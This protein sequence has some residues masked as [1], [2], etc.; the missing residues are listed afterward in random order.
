MGPCR[1]RVSALGRGGGRLLVRGD[2]GGDLEVLVLVAGT[3]GGRTVCV[4]SG[5]ANVGLELKVY[6]SLVG[7]WVFPVCGNAALGGNLVGEG[8]FVVSQE[9]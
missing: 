7:E 6:S 9:G 3:R 5:L 8:F 4:G 1:T 2:G